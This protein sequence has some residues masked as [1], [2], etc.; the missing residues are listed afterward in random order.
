M[1]VYGIYPYVDTGHYCK[2]MP[3][4]WGWGEHMRDE[5]MEMCQSTGSIYC[6]H[7]FKDTKNTCCTEFKEL[8]LSCGNQWQRWGNRVNSVVFFCFF[9]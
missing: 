8:K 1:L 2:Q 7:G 9:F 4:V 5:R 3:D 6:L